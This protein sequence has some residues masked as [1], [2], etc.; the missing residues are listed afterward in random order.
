MRLQVR[1]PEGGYET[2]MLPYD[3][4]PDGAA[5]ALPRIQRIFKRYVEGQT[6]LAKAGQESNTASSHQ[7][8]DWEELIIRF[9]RER[10]QAN[11]RTWR[12]KYLPVLTRT[13]VVMG[14][15]NRP[16]D[17]HALCAL[18]LE[19]WEHGGRQRQIMRQN[20]YA[21]LRF[22]VE[23]GELKSAYLPPSTSPE[24]R[25]P[26]REGYALSD[27]QILR[28]LD[29]LPSGEVHE[30][31]HYAFQLCAVYGLRPEELRHLCIRDGIDASEVWTLYRKSKGGRKGELTEPRRLN[32]LVVRNEDGT[33]LDWQLQD[34]VLKRAEL[35]P[36]GAKGK[37]GEA[38]GTYLRRQD[39]WQ[40]LKVEAKQAGEELVPYTFRH[41]YAKQSHAMGLPLANI[42]NAMGHTIEVHL[43]SYAR[44]TP[45]STAALYA[46]ANL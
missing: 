36:L 15:N 34:R 38:M 4:S 1:A 21:F 5:K 29:G 39:I 33:P 24:I 10:P 25:K 35:P 12:V 28:L 23:R 30:R 42:A 19:R 3:W 43:L 31:W 41:R 8:I 26:K 11:E 40:A 17:G 27:Q 32:P 7:K 6:T 2:L 20:L 46:K 37:A 44:F 16:T 22:A 14:G 13:A 18:A 9:R 45:D